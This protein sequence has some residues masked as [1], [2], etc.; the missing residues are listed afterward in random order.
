M[1]E[2]LALLIEH[3]LLLWW[4][5]CFWLFC[6]QHWLR[7][8]HTAAEC[9]DFRLKFKRLWHLPFPETQFIQEH[10]NLPAGLWVIMQDRAS[11]WS[12]SKHHFG[13]P[14]FLHSQQ[15]T[16]M[17]C[18]GALFGALKQNSDLKSE[19]LVGK[20]MGSFFSK[21]ISKS[22]FRSCSICLESYLLKN[23]SIEFPSVVVCYMLHGI[24]YI[25]EWWF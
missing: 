3:P 16:V 7:C 22:F 14:A 10:E 19:I 15:G 5:Y 24:C 20:S 12:F 1:K 8:L 23:D 9:L 17:G 2:I 6:Y 4:W 18:H 11:L 13:E 25:L 21:C